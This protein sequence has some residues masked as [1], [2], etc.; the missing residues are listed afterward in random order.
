MVGLESRHEYNDKNLNRP[1]L[2][3]RTEEQSPLSKNEYTDL[4]FGKYLTAF[5]KHT[6]LNRILKTHNATKFHLIDAETARECLA[7]MI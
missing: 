4:D 1:T 7:E 2:L 5:P 3:G 6:A